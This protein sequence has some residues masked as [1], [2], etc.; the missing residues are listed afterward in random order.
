MQ[1]RS[2]Q[3]KQP[4]G[5]PH[6]YAPVFPVYVYNKFVGYRDEKPYGFIVCLSFSNQQRI[7]GAVVEIG[8]PA[9]GHAVLVDNLVVDEIR[10]VETFG[11]GVL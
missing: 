2:V 6:L 1:Y 11:V 5:K 9:Y 8:Y 10:Y 3:I 4:F 7:L